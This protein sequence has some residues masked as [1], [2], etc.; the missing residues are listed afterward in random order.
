MAHKFDRKLFQL[1]RLWLRSFPALASARS[2]ALLF[3]GLCVVVSRVSFKTRLKAAS[4]IA[5]DEDDDVEPTLLLKT[6]LLV[7]STEGRPLCCVLFMKQV[8]AESAVYVKLGTSPKIW[9]THLK[10]SLF[11]NCVCSGGGERME[12]DVG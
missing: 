7:R 12:T 1:F 9:P 6:K 4:S 3:Y 11:E 8:A 10:G 5:D 2:I